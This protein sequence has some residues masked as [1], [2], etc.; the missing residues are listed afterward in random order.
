MDRLF[1]AVIAS[2]VLLLLTSASLLMYRKGKPAGETAGA[3]MGL[4][5]VG[6]KR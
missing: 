1:I 3:A 2:A 4:V 6:A 5:T